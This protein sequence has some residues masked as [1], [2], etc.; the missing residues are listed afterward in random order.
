MIPTKSQANGLSYS[1]KMSTVEKNFVL[2][3]ITIFLDSKVD[4]SKNWTRVRGEI[5]AIWPEEKRTRSCY[6]FS[7][8]KLC[9]LGQTSSVDLDRPCLLFAPQPTDLQNLEISYVSNPSESMLRENT[10]LI[11]RFRGKS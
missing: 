3:P 10:G 11:F 9:G 2:E 7:R 6:G 1:R 4:L 8:N 5:S